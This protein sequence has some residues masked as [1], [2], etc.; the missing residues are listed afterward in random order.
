[1]VYLSMKQAAVSYVTSVPEGERNTALSSYGTGYLGH[2]KR[3]GKWPKNRVRIN[4][5]AA[6]MTTDFAV[7]V[8]APVA[9]NAC[10]RSN[11]RRITPEAGHALVILGHA[12]EYL[13]DELVH[14]GR[15][16]SANAAAANWG[17]ELEAVQL[18]MALN[19]QVYYECPE[20]VTVGARLRSMLH[21]RA[22]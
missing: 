4:T 20:V 10:V 5:M 13:T 18:L 19:R 6:S 12:I 2:L 8:S 3:N 1:L 22:A 7:R 14:R 11:R 9:T 16:M 21:L 15:D 17:G